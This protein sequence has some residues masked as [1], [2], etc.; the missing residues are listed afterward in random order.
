MG[1][2]RR[3]G[4][5]GVIALLLV[6]G[7][8]V[9]ADRQ[10]QSASEANS[11]TATAA[12]APTGTVDSGATASSTS[13][14]DDVQTLFNCIMTGN[15]T[16][17]NCARS[18]FSDRGN[19]IRDLIAKLSIG[20]VTSKQCVKAADDL[21]T[22]FIRDEFGHKTLDDYAYSYKLKRCL[23][24]I[25]ENIYQNGMGSKL[26]ETNDKIV[27]VITMEPIVE[28][29]HYWE[30]EK[31]ECTDLLG[32]TDGP[33]AEGHVPLDYPVYSGIWLELKVLISS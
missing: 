15:S 28:C 17:G 13:D 22:S 24:S 33:D 25:G 11:Q 29:E 6:G 9:F 27:D 14:Q 18:A 2:T 3:N 20:D 16:A 4:V 30:S 1:E 7:L 31:V 8:I 5:F 23:G 10:S 19:H 21:S 26:V 32:V 12:A